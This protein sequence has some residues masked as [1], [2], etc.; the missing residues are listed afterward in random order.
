MYSRG[1]KT[2]DG[3]RSKF[4]KKVSETLAKLKIKSSYESR[5]LPYILS[6]TYTGDFFIKDTILEVKGVLTPADKEKMLAVKKQHPHERIVFVFMAPHKRVP[7]SKKTHAQW[8]E[9]N[10]FE[11]IALDDLKD[12]IL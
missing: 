10:G 9:K 3:F 11:W 7:H 5:K 12:F 2:R 8:A 6:K 4:E 1:Q